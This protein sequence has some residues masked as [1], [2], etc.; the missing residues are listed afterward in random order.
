MSFQNIW[1]L[2]FFF[3]GFINLLNCNF[4]LHFDDDTW[5]KFFSFPRLYFWRV[6]FVRREI[7]SQS[8][9][10]LSWRTTHCRPIATADLK[11]KNRQKWTRYLHTTLKTKSRS[12]YIDQTGFAVRDSSHVELNGHTYCRSCLWSPNRFSQV[13][14]TF[15][16]ATKGSFQFL[17][18]LPFINLSNSSP[19]LHNT[20]YKSAESNGPKNLLAKIIFSQWPLFKEVNYTYE[21]TCS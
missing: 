13:P 5:T 15:I 16:C 21:T 1:T 20:T 14:S 12:I 3:E 17:N 2:Q 11:K 6:N 19:S 8:P 10:P 4:V 9:L 7:V 18:H